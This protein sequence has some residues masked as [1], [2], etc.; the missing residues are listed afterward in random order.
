MNFAE[1]NMKKPYSRMNGMK[2]V[3]GLSKSISIA[4]L[5]VFLSANY[6]LAQEAAKPK[7]IGAFYV[8]GKVGLKWKSVEGASEYR[9]YR[10]AVGEDFQVLK[11]LEETHYFDTELVP[12]TTYKYKVAA[13]VDGKEIFSSEKTVTI[14]GAAVGEF[15]PPTWVGLRIEQDKIFL[16]W[17][18]VPGAM[19][20]NIYRSTTPGGEYEL[21]GNAT[22]SKYA[23]KDGLTPGETYYYVITAIDEQ[24]EETEYSEERSIKFGL[25]AEER[26]ALEAA[27]T[28]IVLED[29]KL[30][31]LFDITAAGKTTMN[32]PAD[33][34]LNSQ[35]NIY[36]TDALNQ[37]VHCFD[38]SGNYL[39]SFG[40]KTPAGE[41]EHPPQGT[42]SY[43]FSIFIDK[44]DKVYVTDVINHDIQKFSPTGEFIKRI[45]VETSS[46][47]EPFRPN[48]LYVL[49]DGRIVCTDAGNHRFLIIDQDGKILLSK[50]S[51]GGEPGQFV[52]PDGLTVTRDG[53]ICVVD[54]INSRV[55]EFDLEGNFIR[56]FGE[57]GQTA[58]TFGRPKKIAEGEDGRLWVTDG[59][60]NT[61]QIFTIEG[62]VKSAIVTFEREDVFLATPR[63]LLIKD[64][65]FYIINRV[66]H[67]LMVFKIG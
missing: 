28:K 40:E 52:F 65:R 38:N 11:S 63:G 18:K 57:P 3:C 30:T 5:V 55:Q 44:D 46:G 4:L 45:Q 26:A 67:R 51:R 12:G 29:I 16:N 19:A 62:E 22:V 14:P 50:G 24:F 7:W 41:K 53:I 64:G 48:D 42:F 66:P 58:G 60:G 56:S 10:A 49:D 9:I 35:G 32:Q 6:V 25:S 2:K 59:M 27:T 47:Q 61:V 8:K 43:P 54:A 37:Q 31:Y 15:A 33:L 13:V 20:Y 36:I 23:D 1:I 39:F 17:D 34:A 21:V